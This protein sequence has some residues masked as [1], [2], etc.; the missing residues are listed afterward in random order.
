MSRAT[1]AGL[2]AAA[3]EARQLAN[4]EE[5]EYIKLITRATSVQHDMVEHRS[6]QPSL[7][8]H[9]LW[10]EFSSRQVSFWRSDLDWRV[11]K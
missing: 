2:V 9:A 5:E 10:V 8:E 4:E 7:M 6:T 3:V 11:P 1:A